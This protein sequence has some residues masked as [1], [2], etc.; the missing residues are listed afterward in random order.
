MRACLGMLLLTL[1]ADAAVAHAKDTP[2]ALVICGKCVLDADLAVEREVR[3]ALGELERFVLLPAVKV[4]FEAVQTEL[5]CPEESARC[6]QA[7]A[8]KLKT[9]ALFVATLAQEGGSASLRVVYFDAASSQAPRSVTRSQRGAGSARAWRKELPAM[10]RELLADPPEEKAP[11]IAT[12]PDAAKGAAAK[13]TEAKPTE[14]ATEAKP[15]AAKPTTTTVEAEPE[16]AEPEVATATAEPAQ[17]AASA[18]ATGPGL[19]DAVPLGPLVLGAGGLAVVAAGLVVGAMA[20][21]TQADY[22][23]RVVDSPMQAQLAEHERERGKREA[24]IANVLLGTGAAAIAGAAIWFVIDR[25][26]GDR[27]AQAALSPMLGPDGAGLA[28]AGTWEAR[29]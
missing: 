11:V 2:R 23:M 26:Q 24:L 4:D 15:E 19:F 1:C 13:P 6:L 9:E 14:A 10:L 22:E 27:Q 20:S 16:A 12:K 5:D 17:P 3:R 28:L 8:R 7:A 29:P 25:K 21:S 18:Q